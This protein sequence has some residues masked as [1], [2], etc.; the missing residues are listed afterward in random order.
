MNKCILVGNLARDPELT[1]TSNGVAV[2]RFSIAVSR[3]Y[4]NSDGERETDFLNIVVWRN[5][6]ENCH[7]F[8]KKGSKVGIVGNIQSR[9][10]D[11]TDGTKRYVTEIV[12]EEVE[13]LS[14]KSQDGDAPKT[15]NEEV[16]KLQPI[17]DDGLPF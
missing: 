5:L 2:C 10:Y 15:S 11:A 8:L 6:G 4:A 7:K 16:A 17:D 1:T 9:S 14:T 13:F 12:A 3:R